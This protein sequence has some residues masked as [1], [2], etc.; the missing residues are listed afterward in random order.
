MCV[1]STANGIVMKILI[2]KYYSFCYGTLL[3][4]QALLQYLPLIFESLNISL[5]SRCFLHSVKPLTYSKPLLESRAVTVFS[6]TTVSAV[7]SRLNLFTLIKT[8]INKRAMTQ[9]TEL[10]QSFCSFRP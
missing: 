4:T 8:S 2:Y 7:G 9:Y 6:N 3:K 1:I 5:L 10:Y